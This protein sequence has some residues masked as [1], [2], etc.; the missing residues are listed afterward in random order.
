M[1]NAF[2]DT[3]KHA[4]T[5]IG[6]PCLAVVACLPVCC[7]RIILF[8]WVPLHKIAHRSAR[9]RVQRKSKMEWK[10]VIMWDA[11]ATGF[12]TVQWEFMLCA[13]Y[14]LHGPLWRKVVGCIRS[15]EFMEKKNLCLITPKKWTL[16]IWEKCAQSKLPVPLVK[17]FNFSPAYFLMP[18]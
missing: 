17:L 14:C 4:H 12:C 10:G 11:F 8:G 9:P 1:D 3:H 5:F 16:T 15:N 6:C 18:Y 13:V 2:A 7:C